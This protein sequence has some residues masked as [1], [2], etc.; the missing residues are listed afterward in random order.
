MKGRFTFIEQNIEN[1][2]VCTNASPKNSFLKTFWKK[3][4]YTNYHL[5]LALSFDKNI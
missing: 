4:Y 2:D 1:E 3:P 5:D